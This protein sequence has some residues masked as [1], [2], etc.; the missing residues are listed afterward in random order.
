MHAGII[1][2]AVS[3]ALPIA[4]VV[5][6]PLMDPESFTDEPTGLEDD[7]PEDARGEDFGEAQQPLTPAQRT[8]VCQYSC[9]AVAAIECSLVATSCAGGGVF[10]VG[11][12]AI[13]CAAAIAATCATAAGGVLGCI[14]LCGR[15][16]S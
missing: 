16:L 9:A 7:A 11:A 15:A 10:T 4:D 8:A 3:T 2:F 5:P 12:I 1:L 14:D 6:I 13:P